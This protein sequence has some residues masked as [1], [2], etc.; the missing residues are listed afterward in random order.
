MDGL[1]LASYLEKSGYKIKSKTKTSIVVLVMG[2]RIEKMLELAAK[3]SNMGAKVDKNLKGSSI[4]GVVINNI[5]IVVKADG[6]TGG[7]DVEAQAINDLTDAV[8]CA[9]MATGGP[10]DVKL[11]S[12]TAKGVV[13]VVKTAGTPKSDFH[14]ADE[15]GKAVVHISH[16]KG[17]KPTDFQQWGGVTEKR[18]ADHPEVKRFGMDCLAEFTSKMENG[19]SAWKKIKDKHL[20]M[21]AVFGVNYD[22]SGMDENKV[23]V[24]I[25]GDPGLREIK[26]GLYEL[27]GTGHVSYLGDLP[28]GG[29]DPVLAMIYK[30][31]RDQFGVKG[32]R[33]SIYPYGGR[34]FKQQFK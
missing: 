8:M 1:E 27:T 17:S 34:T 21:M 26:P 16:K 2:N 20:K 6:K 11:G 7:L 13:D 10:I 9:I 29:F 5:K 14:L 12:R 23:D 25:Q 4:G 28:S 24:L 15:S 31:D 32:G 33:A 22:K 19:R 3:L 18:I 30:G